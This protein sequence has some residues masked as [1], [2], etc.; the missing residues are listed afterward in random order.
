MSAVDAA[1]QRPS[2]SRAPSIDFPPTVPFAPAGGL[3]LH[4]KGLRRRDFE[5]IV[6]LSSLSGRRRVRRLLLASAALFLSTL[7]ALAVGEIGVRLYAPQKDAMRWFVTDKR[8]GFT[9]RPNFHQ[10]YHYP[11]NDYVMDIQTNSLGLR[12]PE[13]DA[14][15]LSDPDALRV[16]LLG[17]SFT[18]GHAVQVEETFGHQ[19]AQRLKGASRRSIV[20]NAGVGGWGTLQEVTYARDHMPFYRPDF[21]VL[22]FCAND[23]ENDTQYRY[24]L[25]DSDR[26][27]V[28]FPG[29]IFLR[30]NSQLYRFVHTQVSSLIH[31][32]LVQRKAR[33]HGEV[34][35]L[36]E[37]SVSVISPKEWKRTLHEIRSFAADFHQFNPDDILL[38]QA[39]APWQ[40]DIR[41]NLMTLSD[42]NTQYIDLYDRTASLT[43]DERRQP[44]DG[45]W[46][47]L[48]HSIAAAEI[49]RAIEAEGQPVDPAQATAIESGTFTRIAGGL[50]N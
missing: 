45:H 44:H 28:P 10:R 20:I 23:P 18:F 36:D 3:R 7:A 12:G 8:Y 13:L 50:F 2:A 43:A 31:N 38:I 21:V 32:F 49:F 35:E 22:T 1:H 42:G 41:R 40:D 27:I 19:L 5:L 26:G 17:D 33:E 4:A 34:I 14:Q 46:S 25:R 11:T 37:Q 24:G 16:L 6:M 29:K 47:P 30:N 39:S 48:V 15:I 9:N